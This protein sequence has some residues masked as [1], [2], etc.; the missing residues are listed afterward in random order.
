VLLLLDVAHQPPPATHDVQGIHKAKYFVPF[1]AVARL[2]HIVRHTVSRPHQTGEG[3]RCFAV[4]ADKDIVLRPDLPRPI[5]RRVHLF[6]V[7][8]V[9]RQAREQV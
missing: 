5:R 7:D 3:L 6:V 4:R 9:R 2:K 1:L 8:D